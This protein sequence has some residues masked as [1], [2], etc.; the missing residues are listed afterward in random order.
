MSLR[1]VSCVLAYAHTTIIN[2]IRAH[3]SPQNHNRTPAR[4]KRKQTQR[5]RT[6]VSFHDVTLHAPRCSTRVYICG[7]ALSVCV[8][9]CF[10]FRRRVQSRAHA[11][12]RELAQFP[13]LRSARRRLSSAA[14]ADA[15]V[16]VCTILLNPRQAR[17][18]FACAVF[19]RPTAD[20]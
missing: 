10:F 14:T 16:R 7:G 2:Y 13:R 9:Q 6:A 5:T 4:V 15:F 19:S 18:R 20:R 8:Q 17:E 11:R 12:S 1:C 3:Y